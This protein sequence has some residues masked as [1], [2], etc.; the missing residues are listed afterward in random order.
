MTWSG[1]RPSDDACTYGYLIPSNMF[2]VVA[3]GYLEEIAREVLK[4]PEM[5]R[6]AAVLKEEIYEGIEKYGITRREG[7]GEVYAYEAD[8]F[9]EFNLMDDAN[10][11]SLLSMDYIGYKGRSREVAENTRKLI[12]SETNPFYYKGEKAAGI[13]SPH[14]PAGYIWHIALCL[15]LI[16]I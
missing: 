11:P 9:G 8:G 6:E 3:L 4:L 10:V 7:F 14:T 16:H 1:F 13:G 12:L 15:S 5:A 2:A